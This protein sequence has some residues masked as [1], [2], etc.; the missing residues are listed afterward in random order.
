MITYQDLLEVG[1]NDTARMQFVF[2]SVTKHRNSPAYLISQ[3]ADDYDR[4]RNTTIMQYQKL[5]YTMSGQAVPDNYSANY[6]LCSNFFNRFVTQETQYLLGNG[7]S[8]TEES[9]QE[10]LGKDFDT[11]LQKAGHEALVSG[12]AFGFWNLDHMDVFNLREFVP[13]YDEENGALMAGIR[14]W[15]IDRD[16]PMRATLYELDGYTDYIKKDGK[17]EILHDKRSYKLL[18]RST[19]ADGTEIYAGENYPTFPIVPLWGNTHKQSELIGLREQIDA[20]DLIR[21]G[22]CN[23]LDDFSQIFWV[24]QNGGGM[25]D[26]DLAKFVDRMRT[27]K[28]AVVEDGG[29]TAESHTVE[30][31]YASREALLDRL[32]SDLY[33]DYMALDTKAIAGGAATATQIRAAYEPLNNKADMF[34]YCVVD[35]LHGILDIAGIDDTP[36]FT[37]SLIVNTQEEIQTILSAASYLDETYITK[38]VL[39]I[40]GDGDKAEEILAQMDADEL[41]RGGVINGQRA[42]GDGQAD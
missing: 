34:E 30:I 32:R 6:K 11:A 20:Y 35:F 7:V 14:F 37:R 19:E 16:K 41:I 31:P 22:F 5:L 38:K 28:A 4:K 24:I 26:I 39:D 25:D 17:E 10:K 12:V 42:S 18:L 8:W 40:L 21:S 2:G 29:A 1:D 23:D 9:T 3:T 15:Q 36:S 33:D 27:V 13:L